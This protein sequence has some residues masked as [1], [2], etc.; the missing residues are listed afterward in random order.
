MTIE[1]LIPH[2]SC[3]VYS[4]TDFEEAKNQNFGEIYLVTGGGILKHVKLKHD[5]F[6]RIKVDAIP[7]YKQEVVIG[8]EINFL[9]AGR[10]PTKFLEEIV[11]FFKDVMNI[12]KADQEAMAHILWNEQEGY[13]IG[14]PDQ[15]VSK[16]SVRYEFNHIKPG[17]VIVLDIHSHNTMPAFFSGTDNSDDRKG[18]YYSGVVGKL[19][20]PRPMF[21]WR[22]NLNEYKKEAK[23]EDIFDIQ[24]SEIKV[25][26]SWLDKVKTY[27]YQGKEHPVTHVWN[28]GGSRGSEEKD[29]KSSWKNWQEERKNGKRNAPGFYRGPHDYGI[30]ELWGG[31]EIDAFYQDATDLYLPKNNSTEARDTRAT[32]IAEETGRVITLGDQDVIRASLGEDYAANVMEY[33]QEAAEAYDQIDA[34]LEDLNECDDL[35]LKIMA[36]AYEKLSS[37]AQV[38][39]AHTG[40]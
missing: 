5:R 20:E 13:H 38:R 32:S 22:F 35:L 34:Y 37:Q 29:S 21:V 3:V 19:D 4:P 8:E 28:P 27:Q 7:N 30:G 10:I 18:Y 6:V 26:E 15:T 11:Q 14:I 23:V 17:D 2:M 39:L 25:P 12:K 24:R 16:A 9:P 33:G 36:I 31:S 40:F 1:T